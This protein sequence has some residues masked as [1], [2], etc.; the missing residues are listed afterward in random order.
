MVRKAT[1]TPT[2]PPLSIQPLSAAAIHKTGKRR[3]STFAS[4]IN[5][6]KLYCQGAINLLPQKIR[7]LKTQEDFQQIIY[8]P[9]FFVTLHAFL[10]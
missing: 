1:N 4:N 5:A 9:S 7:N 6:L 3:C 10:I 2:F 8:F